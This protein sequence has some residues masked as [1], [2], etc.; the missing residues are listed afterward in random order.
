VTFRTFVSK[1]DQLYTVSDFVDA[2][3]APIQFLSQAEKRAKQLEGLGIDEKDISDVSVP[4]RQKQEPM[5]TS[6]DGAPMSTGSTITTT[7]NQTALQSTGSS[8][9]QQ[10]SSDKEKKGAA[11]CTLWSP[12]LA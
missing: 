9:I 11:N 1:A 8:A 12:A 7:S 4:V 2:L 6:T 10:A 3:S 5:A